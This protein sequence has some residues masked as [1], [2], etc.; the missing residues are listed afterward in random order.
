MAQ[1]STFYSAYSVNI[2]FVTSKIVDNSNNKYKRFILLCAF[3]KS[4]KFL[5]WKSRRDI[6]TFLSRIW[7]LVGPWARLEITSKRARLPLPE[8]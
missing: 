7:P 2:I 1:A 3:T 8:I 5:T 4:Y 6:G